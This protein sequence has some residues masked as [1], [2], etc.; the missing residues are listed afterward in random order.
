MAMDFMAV[1]DGFESDGD[2]LFARL[3]DFETGSAAFTAERLAIRPD[4]TQEPVRPAGMQLDD[5]EVVCAQKISIG[6]D[7]LECFD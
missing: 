7:R 4:T 5:S 6:F 1:L 2:D 3:A